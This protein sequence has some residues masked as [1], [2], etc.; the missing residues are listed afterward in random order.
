MIGTLFSILLAAFLLFSPYVDEASINSGI[1][2][3]TMIAVAI[4]FLILTA[5]GFAL[6]WLPM[7][8][9]ELNA[10]PHIL[11][12]YQKD[13]GIKLSTGWVVVFSL[14]SI[15]LGI[16]VLQTHIPDKKIVFA[17]WV[18]LFGIAIDALY[19]SFRKV[20]EYLNPF[21]VVEL[22]SKEAQQCI[23][24]ERELDL[25]HWI[26]GL[27][28]VAMKAINKHSISLSNTAINQQ[29]QTAR[30]F[31]QSAKSLSH[32]SQD[33]QSK[34]LGITDK[35]SYIMF[36]LY[37]RLDLEF[38]SALKIHLEPTCSNIIVILGKIAIDAAKYDVSMATLP[39]RF[40]GK[41]A[42]AAQEKDLSETVIK[43]SCAL[44]ET[45]RTIL[46][47]IDITYAEIKD[48]FLSIVN[49][50][51]S[52][53]KGAFRKDKSTNI[54]LLIQPLIELK[55]MFA[56]EKISKHQ[57]APAITQS[58]DRVLGEFEA[59]QMVM[60]TLP[61]IPSIASEPSEEPPPSPT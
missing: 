2:S 60:N 41:F 27:S 4:L 26:D 9:A 50:L 7:Q 10:T 40:L 55:A 24:N 37:Q 3:H 30:L 46:N 32:H 15:I 20:S 42:N 29:Q 52:L 22:F 44:L 19:H 33:K 38:D 54:A 6:S 25:C 1:W 45:G 8:K 21:A 48:P 31:L 35:V 36:Y 5:I 16:V 49:S 14:T 34:E 61:T 53:A 28:E 39:L 56:S 58:I 11:E 23:Q 17:V 18:V 43:A 57:D 51:E 59:L 12:M 13:K 47:D